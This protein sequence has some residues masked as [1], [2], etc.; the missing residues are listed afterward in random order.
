MEYRQLTEVVSGV[1]SALTAARQNEVQA[2]EQELSSCEHVL[3][4]QQQDNK[5]RKLGMLLINAFSR[6]EK[7]KKSKT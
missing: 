5:D 6:D 7:T 3:C 1:L 2:W 4:L